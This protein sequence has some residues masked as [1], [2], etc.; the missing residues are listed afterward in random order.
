MRL[1]GISLAVFWG[2][3]ACLLQAGSLNVV[4]ITNR[5]AQTEAEKR[6]TLHEFSATRRY[7]L[8]NSHWRH[9]A[10][11]VVRVSFKRGSGKTFQVLEVE[12]AE[13][14][15][16]KVLDRLIQGE[17][18]ASRS[19]RQDEN[20]VI[21]AHYDFRLIGTETL[22]GRLCY[23]MDIHP[24]MKSKYLLQGKAWVDAEDFALARIEGRPTASLGF[25]VGK[26]YIVQQFEK[27][28]DFWMASH[29]KSTSESHILGK[30]ELNIDY[31]AYD[32]ASAQRRLASRRAA[33]ASLE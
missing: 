13:G 18:Q 25:W 24:K 2:L 10:V 21:P 19:D 33:T 27:Q 4:E 17:E 6:S 3:Q 7:A 8:R 14:M 9:D 11:M 26:P 31:T 22:A 23:V 29:N 32:L 5:L 16:R 20:A 1:G 30:S 28:G 12:G 15:A